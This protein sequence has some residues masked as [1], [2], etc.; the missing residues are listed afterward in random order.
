MLYVKRSG[1]P[2]SGKG[3]FT[4]VPF[5]RGD[6]VVEYKGEIVPWK[7]CLVREY[8]GK[9][10][11]FMYVTKDHC[12]DARPTT[13]HKARYANDAKGFTKKA[14]V[15]NNSFYEMRGKKVF[16]VARKFIPEGSEILVGYG[17]EYWDTLRDTIKKQRKKKAADR[18]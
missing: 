2:N 17:K 1:L 16:I 14:G 6:V 10:G 9:G 8:Y 15:K 11:Y 18:K 4:K 5:K 7:E 3:L 13:Q 12:I